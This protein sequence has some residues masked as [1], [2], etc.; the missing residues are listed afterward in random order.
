MHNSAAM[1]CQS[2]KVRELLS[3]P[4]TEGYMMAHLDYPTRQTG[5]CLESRFHASIHPGLLGF[6][7]G[8]GLLQNCSSNN[9]SFC[10]ESGL[11]IV[12]PILNGMSTIF[13]I[14]CYTEGS[15][16]THLLS[17]LVSSACLPYLLEMLTSGVSSI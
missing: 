17:P 5:I 16:R 6:M 2:P 1:T 14:L 9:C 8:N 4:L 3:C 12:L 7:C 13:V 11:L 15:W 10:R